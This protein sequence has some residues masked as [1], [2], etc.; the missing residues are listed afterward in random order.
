MGDG[1]DRDSD[2]RLSLP[3]TRAADEPYSAYFLNDYYGESIPFL[4]FR[5]IGKAGMLYGIQPLDPVTLGLAPV[6]LLAAAALA[7]WVPAIR[8]A[9]ADPTVTLRSE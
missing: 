1:G 9:S 4:V 8:A 7:C 3:R 5:L 6:V 2:G